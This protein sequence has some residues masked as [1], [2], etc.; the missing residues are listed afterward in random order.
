MVCVTVLV[1]LG[2]VAACTEHTTPKES[3]ESL[4]QKSSTLRRTV[5]RHSHLRIAVWED[6]P[7]MFF[8]DPVTNVR[9]GFEIE[10]AK[11]IA[12][13]LGFDE[14]RI[15]W[16]TIRNLPDRQSILGEDRAD[17][18]VAAF[19][20]TDE[21]KKYVEFAGPYMLVPQAVLVR[22]DRKKPLETI[23]D[24]RAPDVHVC[25]T[26]GSTSEGALKGKGITPDPVDTNAD[27]MAGMKS[28]KYDAFSTD[29]P[30]LAGMQRK[31]K[32]DAKGQDAFEIL[33]LTIADANERIGIAVPH[34][35]TAMS[36]LVAYFLNLWQT[37]PPGASP[38][39]RAY[40]STVGP[41]LDARRYRFQPRVEDPTPP[42]LADYDSKAPHA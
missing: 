40:D 38:W 28:G 31:A 6:V 29:L 5:D 26:T 23:T 21:R 20:I 16:V 33:D 8:R 9:S 2:G 27:C 19:S 42:D 10:I 25:T 13:G 36:G 3:V 7:Y 15:D 41:M 30:I 17:M 34:G 37:G 18:V 39:L 4:R 24:L 35:D 1:V 11:A 12:D 32:E 14:D 22:R